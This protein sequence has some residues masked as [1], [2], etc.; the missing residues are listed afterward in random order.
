[1]VKD[2]GFGVLV[3]CADDY[4]PPASLFPGVQVIH[5]PLDDS[6]IRQR[7]Q[8]EAIAR[9]AAKRV[10]DAMRTGGEVLVT[11]RAGRNRSGLVAGLALLDHAHGPVWTVGH[12]RER[13]HLALSNRSFVDLI[14]R[15]GVDYAS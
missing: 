3:L 14:M 15:I 9:A 12:I 6:D 4:Q 1:M 11:C 10:A 2:A 5:A 8:D 13:R 7:P